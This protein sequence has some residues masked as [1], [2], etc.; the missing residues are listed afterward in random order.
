MTSCRGVIYQKYKNI[1]TNNMSQV[2]I[3]IPHSK[4][5]PLDP[6]MDQQIAGLATY[7]TYSGAKPHTETVDEIDYTVYQDIN[8]KRIPMTVVGITLQAGG[9]VEGLQMFIKLDDVTAEVT[10]GIPD[11]IL[12]DEEGVET[13]KTW[14]QWAAGTV[15]TGTDAKFYIETSNGTR[16]YSASELA[17]VYASLVSVTDFKAAMPQE[18]I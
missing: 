10:A 13:V 7:A 4:I 9:D 14:E 3:K 6:S 1:P 5:N 18:D 16:Y 17:P 11:R 8:P 12:T 15:H 2:K